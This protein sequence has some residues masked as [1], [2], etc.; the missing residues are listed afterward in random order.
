MPKRRFGPCTNNQV[1]ALSLLGHL[2]WQEDKYNATYGTYSGVDVY[3]Y[4]NRISIKASGKEYIVLTE[5][6]YGREYVFQFKTDT[7]RGKVWVSING[8]YTDEQGYDLTN[9]N[10]SYK[11]FLKGLRFAF[12]DRL[13]KNSRIEIDY[14]RLYEISNAVSEYEERIDAIQEQITIDMLTKRPMQ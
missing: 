2:G 6:T 7:E 5:S 10:S 11:Y 14:I 13:L 9:Y 8:V 12:K 1:I 3:I 4:P